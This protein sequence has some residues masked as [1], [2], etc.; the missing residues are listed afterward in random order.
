MLRQMAARSCS[1]SRDSPLAER[2]FAYYCNRRS[3]RNPMGSRPSWSG[4]RAMCTKVAGTSFTRLAVSWLRALARCR[5]NFTSP[6][7]VETQ[8]LSAVVRVISAPSDM[9][10]T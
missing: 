4:R 7:H 1:R 3:P 5:S 9:L 2:P 8:L 10:I 6:P